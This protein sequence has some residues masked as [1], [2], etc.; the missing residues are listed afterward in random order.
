M[1]RDG[2]VDDDWVP[3]KEEKSADYEHIYLDTHGDSLCRLG[4][5][6]EQPWLPSAPHWRQVEG[7]NQVTNQRTLSHDAI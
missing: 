6:S 4:W 2:E 3:K 1:G 7:R 5:D